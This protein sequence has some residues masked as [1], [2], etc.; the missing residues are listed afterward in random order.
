MGHKKKRF[1]IDGWLIIDKPEGLTSTTVTNRVKNVLNASKVG[2][3]GTLDPMAT[4]VLPLAF[5]EA[6]KTLTYVVE[7]LKEYKFTIRWGENRTT[8]DAEGTVIGTS[9]R[10]PEEN[11]ILA[12]L[13][14]FTGE[15]EQVP[16]VYSA[17][18]IGGRRAYELA[19]KN[20]SVTL[21]PRLIQIHQFDLIERKDADH[22]VFRVVSGKG[23]YM[24]SLARDVALELGTMGHIAQ[25]RRVSVGPFVEKDAISLDKVVELGHT[26]PANKILWPVEA[27][28]DD[29]PALVLAEEE[30]RK[31]KC[32][33]PVSALKIKESPPLEDLK[34]GDLVVAMA[35]GKPI[36][37]ARFEGNL[38]RPFRVLNL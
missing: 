24:R 5:G 14:R 6:T 18:K 38:I 33:Q 10:R 36:A 37:L 7:G 23:A 35:G 11:E 12:I 26:A 34:Q 2:H 21:K 30:A 19:R 29:I 31:L 27:A 20:E 28:L 4:G 17:V 9:N 15:I 1:P 3:G 25:L 8:D 22:A 16:P 32:G 13:G